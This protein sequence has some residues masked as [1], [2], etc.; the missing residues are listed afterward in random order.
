[1]PV[2]I[3]NVVVS[4]IVLRRGRVGAWGLVNLATVPLWLLAWLAP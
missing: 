2:E 4:V 1:M 3:F